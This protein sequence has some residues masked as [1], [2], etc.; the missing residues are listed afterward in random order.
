MHAT[1]HEPPPTPL[2]IHREVPLAPL[3]TL[4]LGGHAESLVVAENPE[5]VRAA[6]GWAAGRGAPVTVLGGGSNVVVADGGVSGLVVR[7]GLRGIAVEP[8]G[9]HTHVT[10]AAGEPWDELVAWSTSRRLTGIEC[11][12]G[13]PGTAGATPIQNVGAYGQEIAD[14]VHAVR[15]LDRRTLE[16]RSLA[17]VECGFAYRSSL[18]KREP[19]RFVIL[20][21]TLALRTGPARTQRHEELARVLAARRSRPAPADVR[22]AVLDLRRAKSMLVEP[23]DENRRS[24]G[25]FFLNPVIDR[26][27][28]DAV[29]RRAVSTGVV[30]TPD[31]I[32][33]F[34]ASSTRVKLPA[35]WLVE[36]AG[37][38]RG[39]RRGPVGIS[40]RHALALVHHGAGTTADLIA[41][42]REV[43]G[44]VA[45]RFGILLRP[46]PVFLGFPPGDPLAV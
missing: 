39:T 32:P 9:Q 26:A 30:A 27:E 14:V 11:L 29:C 42:A 21:V 38:P 36:H 4:E 12:S 35:A 6:L 23:C 34:P 16:E 10:A 20:S 46:E 8:K 28:L 44:A 15:V 41:L 31:L 25:S 40:S 1:G 7:I 45:G 37:F 24:A 22:A 5:A 43:R 18:F 17:S 2:D 19:D 33:R 13:I 3:T